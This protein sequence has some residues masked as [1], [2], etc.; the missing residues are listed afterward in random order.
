MPQVRQ[1]SVM[2]DNNDAQADAEQIKN[3][4]KPKP[5]NE[6]LVKMLEALLGEAKQGGAQGMMVIKVIDRGTW[7]LVQSGEFP[8]EFNCGAGMIMHGIQQ[9]WVMNLLAQAQTQQQ[10]GLARATEADLAALPK[11]FMK[12]G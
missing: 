4:G 11:G 2:G 7:Q 5:V 12:R 1:E 3:V 8:M 9:G 6:H 10:R